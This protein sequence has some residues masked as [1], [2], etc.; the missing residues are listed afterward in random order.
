MVVVA[1]EMRS[2]SCWR[3]IMGIGRTREVVEM[4]GMQMEMEMVNRQSG[5][6]T[7]TRMH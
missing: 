3:R 4:M 1:G 7:L 2:A 6:C 5:E